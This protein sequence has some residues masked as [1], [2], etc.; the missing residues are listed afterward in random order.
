MTMAWL[1]VTDPFWSYLKQGATPIKLSRSAAVGFSIGICPLIGAYLPTLALQA[2]DECT[3]GCDECAVLSCKPC[4]NATTSDAR[5]GICSQH[6]SLAILVWEPDPSKDVYAC[7][8]FMLPGRG[9]TAGI[10]TGL[11]VL[12][13][14]VSKSFFHGPMMLLANFVALPVNVSAHSAHTSPSSNGSE[15]IHMPPQNPAL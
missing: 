7:N 13:L 12:I 10:S 4:C 2:V 14:L 3:A 6:H 9:A 8:Q 11:C 5:P 1:Q 15:G